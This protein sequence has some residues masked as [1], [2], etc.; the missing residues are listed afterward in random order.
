M[1][2]Y[3]PSDKS[4]EELVTIQAKIPLALRDTL[5]KCITSRG[6]TKRD[7]IIAAIKKFID[8]TGV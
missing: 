7:L 3:L 6:I 5:N 8:D 1:N 2:D 4:N